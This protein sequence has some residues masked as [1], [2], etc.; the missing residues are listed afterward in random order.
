MTAFIARIRKLIVYIVAVTGGTVTAAAL[1]AP[2]D[3]IVPVIIGV[4]GAIVHYAVPNAPPAA[5]TPPSLAT[6]P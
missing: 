4:L 1:P 6:T 5:T 2:Y 3:T